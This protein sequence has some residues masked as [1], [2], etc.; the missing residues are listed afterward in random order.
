MLSNHLINL[1]GQLE[2]FCESVVK[3]IKDSL[4]WP[5]EITLETNV[6]AWTGKVPDYLRM[7][8]GEDVPISPPLDKIDEDLKA[9]T[10][11]IASYQVTEVTFL[12]PFPHSTYSR[13]HS[14]SKHRHI[15]NTFQ[16]SNINQ[17]G[18]CLCSLA[19]GKDF[20]VFVYYV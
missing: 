20:F 2:A 14:L 7:A 12:C 6:G 10:Q 11:D 16:I 1:I 3:K 9:S 4:G 18:H 5:G 13:L 17:L 15:S 8:V 19:S